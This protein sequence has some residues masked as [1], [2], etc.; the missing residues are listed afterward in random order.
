MMIEKNTQAVLVSENIEYVNGEKYLHS[1][2]LFDDQ[3]RQLLMEKRFNRPHQ[4]AFTIEQV[5]RM[6]DQLSHQQK[7]IQNTIAHA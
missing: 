7:S 6:I 4:T 5:K 3:S 2:Q 1:I